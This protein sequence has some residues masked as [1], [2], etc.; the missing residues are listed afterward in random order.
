[1]LSNS[2]VEPKPD[3]FELNIEKYG[4][5]HGVHFLFSVGE[6]LNSFGTA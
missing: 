2:V 1:M 6:R 3:K 4:T 5:Y